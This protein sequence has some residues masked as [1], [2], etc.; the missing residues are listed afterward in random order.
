[1]GGQGDGETRRQGDGEMG[2][3]TRKDLIL[4][5]PNSSLLTPNSSLLTPNSSLFIPTLITLR[6]RIS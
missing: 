4:T 2:R 3:G 6:S 1:M 5:I